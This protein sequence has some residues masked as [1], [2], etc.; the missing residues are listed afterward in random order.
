MKKLILILLIIG[1]INWG[2][3][4]FFNYNLVSG[5]FGANLIV[6]SRIIYAVVGLAALYAISFLFRDN[7]LHS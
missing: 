1:G 2:L 5:I 7:R 6:I 4:G 3:I